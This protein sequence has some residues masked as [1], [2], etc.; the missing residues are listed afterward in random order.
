MRCL[1]WTVTVSLSLTKFL[2][3][4]FRLSTTVGLA[5][6][7][8]HSPNTPGE[9]CVISIV[10]PTFFCQFRNL[11]TVW[12]VCRLLCGITGTRSVRIPPSRIFCSCRF[13]RHLFV[14]PPAFL[15]YLYPSIFMIPLN[16]QHR[17]PPFSVDFLFTH[18]RPCRTTIDRFFFFI[19][20]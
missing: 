10:P 14:G 12:K 9:Y 11:S 19:F 8:L 13:P 2:F 3:Q 15:S 6:W 18:F 20:S 4:G 7:R 17:P 1:S 16:P 5:T